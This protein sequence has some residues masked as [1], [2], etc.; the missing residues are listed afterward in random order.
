MGSFIDDIKLHPRLTEPQ[1]FLA[2]NQ[3]QRV[4]TRGIVGGGS[5]SPG[6]PIYAG[7]RNCTP[8]IP[9]AVLVQKVRLLADG[10]AHQTC[11]ECVDC[12]EVVALPRVVHHLPL[13]SAPGVITCRMPRNYHEGVVCGQW[14]VQFCRSTYLFRHSYG[15]PGVLP[16]L[17]RGLILVCVHDAWNRF[18]QVRGAPLIAIVAVLGLSVEAVTGSWGEGTAEDASKMLHDK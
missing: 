14:T 11:D 17:C 6:R 7:S 8:C 9:R 18:L 5:A 16:L 10:A 15:V 12:A 4:S 1:G 3:Y 2:P 13:S